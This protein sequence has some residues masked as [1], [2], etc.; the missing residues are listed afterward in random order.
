MTAAVNRDKKFC[1]CDSLSG[2]SAAKKRGSLRVMKQGREV[3]ST[4]SENEGK[5]WEMLRK[6]RKEMSIKEEEVHWVKL[7]M[8]GQQ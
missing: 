6:R 5:E 3:M 8:I 7:N 2:N 4:Q 1:R